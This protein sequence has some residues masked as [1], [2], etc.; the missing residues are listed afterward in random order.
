MEIPG[1]IEMTC[2]PKIRDA[3]TD[4]V[5]LIAK[6]VVAAAHLCDFEDG[7]EY[8]EEFTAICSRE[9]TLYSY[10]NARVVTVDGVPVGSMVSYPGDIY[11]EARKVT[12]RLFTDVSQ[13]VSDATGTE[14][15][16]G[17][18]YLDS[19]AVLPAHRNSG[20]GSLLIRDA[21]ETGRS[22]GYRKFALIVEK[23][24]PGLQE[25]YASFGFIPGED[26]NFFGDSYMRMTLEG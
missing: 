9:D 6:C 12:F 24:S 18:W 25:Y 21:I 19:L 2:M 7:T 10:R 3:S 26:I 8:D 22:R 5:A 11:E 14:T 16:P 15:F 1:D 13:E 23:S 20:L 4:D 17:E